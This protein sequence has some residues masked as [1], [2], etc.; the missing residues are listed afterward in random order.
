ELVEDLLHLERCEDRLDQHGAPDRAAR[1]PERLLRE[2]ER[3]RPQPRL[4]MALQLRQVEVRPASALEQLAG[5]V[6][7][8]EPEIE[9]A[10]RHRLTVEVHV[11]LDE[12]PAARAND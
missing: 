8:D 11:P 6:V 7:H 9:E 12:M 3:L 4:E 2:R 1:N 5:V 10:R